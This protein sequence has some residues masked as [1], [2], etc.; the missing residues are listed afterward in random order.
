VFSVRKELGFYIYFR[1][2]PVF[3]GLIVCTIKISN[4]H[5]NK[6]FAKLITNS[7][8]SAQSNA[9]CRLYLTLNIQGFD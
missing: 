5:K 6:I 1:V 3:Q 9:Y 8:A 4:P 7:T 2:M